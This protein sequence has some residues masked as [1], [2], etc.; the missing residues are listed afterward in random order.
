[1][2]CVTVVS[3]FIQCANVCVCVCECAWFNRMLF[4]LSQYI[5]KTGNDRKCPV[6]ACHIICTHCL[7]YISFRFTAIFLHDM[8]VYVCFRFHTVCSVYLI[9]FSEGIASV[10]YMC[11]R[12]C[13][14]LIGYIHT[15]AFLLLILLLLHLQEN[16]IKKKIRSSINFMTFSDKRHPLYGYPSIGTFNRFSSMKS[17]FS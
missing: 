17:S 15:F 2:L 7:Y 13:F 6:Y 16:K 12:T 9:P 4:S 14:Q 3:W 1:M 8:C 10:L 11:Y 5:M